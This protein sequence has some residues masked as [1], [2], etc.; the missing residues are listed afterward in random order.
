MIFLVIL[1]DVLQ[2]CLFSGLLLFQPFLIL[3]ALVK[4]LDQ[5][6]YVIHRF[7]LLVPFPSS[8]NFS[9]PLLDYLCTLH[10]LLE[11]ITIFDAKLCLQ[12]KSEQLVA[13]LNSGKP[14]ELSKFLLDAFF[15]GQA[16]HRGSGIK[17]L[18]WQTVS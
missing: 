18:W 12:A 10:D 9:E 1:S 15:L 7:L 11:M 8:P 5:S 13:V 14:I 3:F 17:D 16:L 4:V 6:V 2:P